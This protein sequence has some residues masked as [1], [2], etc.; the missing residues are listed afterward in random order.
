MHAGDSKYTSRTI[1]SNLDRLFDVISNELSQLF[2][3]IKQSI[4]LISQT[5]D[6]T[7]VVIGRLSGEKTKLLKTR[8]SKPVW[9][10][11]LE[12][13]SWEAKQ[14]K[15]DIA[16]TSE[17]IK[18]L[19]VIWN[20]FEELRNTLVAYRDNMEFFKVKP[21]SIS[22][23]S[24]SDPWISWGI[25][26]SLVA[27]HAAHHQ[28]A[29]EDEVDALGGIIDNFRLTVEASKSSSNSVSRHGLLEE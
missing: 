13:R 4:P 2:L 18:G 24:L 6:L 21:S 26:D 9:S 27:Y 17:S 12:G 16:L 1:S 22:S 8:A 23:E 7:M 3:R 14:L 20:R 5:S 25:Q 11:I 29:P 19:N 28:I 10:R 15:R